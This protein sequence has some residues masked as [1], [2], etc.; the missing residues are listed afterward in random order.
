MR[1]WT[2]DLTILLADWSDQNNRT[3]E[4]CQ[5]SLATVEECNPCAEM[6]RSSFNMWCKK[7]RHGRGSNKLAVSCSQGRQLPGQSEGNLS[8]TILTTFDWNKTS[9][10]KEWIWTGT[11]WSISPMNILLWVYMNFSELDWNILLLKIK[12]FTLTTMSWTIVSEQK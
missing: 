8:Q 4:K 12:L 6:P 11:F 3:G 10:R 9:W 5:W 2:C 7:D 1:F